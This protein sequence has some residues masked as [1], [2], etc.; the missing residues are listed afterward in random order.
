MNGEARTKRPEP[1]T[2]APLLPCEVCRKATRHSWDS[3]LLDSVSPEGHVRNY[4]FMFA[5]GRCKKLRRWGMYSLRVY[6][7]SKKG[8]D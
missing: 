1:E 6:P 3:T 4:V 2:K 8:R 5:C 7:M